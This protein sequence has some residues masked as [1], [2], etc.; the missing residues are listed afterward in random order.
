MRAAAC[1]KFC[2]NLCYECTYLAFLA[3][4][5]HLRISNLRGFNR[6][7][8]RALSKPDFRQ[9]LLGVG[10]LTPAESEWQGPPR[11]DC[12]SIPPGA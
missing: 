12:S 6:R 2:A 1:A 4:S 9:R 3:H 5:A 10:V 11:I 7:L 8:S